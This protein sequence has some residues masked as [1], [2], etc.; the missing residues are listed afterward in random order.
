MSIIVISQTVR[1]SMMG[2]KSAI[3]MESERLDGMDEIT[4][5]DK[6]KSKLHSGLNLVR[7]KLK[8]R[9]RLA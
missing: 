6:I 7:N 1:K 5:T 4:G 3:C 9:V 8:S 2:E